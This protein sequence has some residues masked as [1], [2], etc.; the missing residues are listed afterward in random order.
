RTSRSSS[1]AIEARVISA[2]GL[3]PEDQRGRPHCDRVTWAQFGAL[4]PPAVDLGAVRRI[5]V[6]DPMSGALLP[7]FCVTAR[8]VRV[9]DLDVGVFRAADHDAPLPDLV[10]LAVPR[11]R[12]N[13]LLE[14]ELLRG[15]GLRV[16]LLPPLHYR[17]ARCDI[18]RHRFV[19]YR[20]PSAL[21]HPSRASGLAHLERLVVLY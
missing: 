16:G 14:S 19:R 4:Q 7:N 15:H 2:S 21:G 3:P 20:T 11:K 6:Y 5:E 12:C 1:S 10:L 17:R 8:H 18:G 13:L 9:L